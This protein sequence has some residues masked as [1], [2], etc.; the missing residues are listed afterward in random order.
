[1]S[2]NAIKRAIKSAGRDKFVADIS[3]DP[4]AFEVQLKSP[5]INTDFQETIWVYG[6]H[7]LDYGSS[8]QDMLEDL[9]MWMSDIEKEAA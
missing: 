8:V 2:L 7:N 3:E 6:K 1:M 9:D 4:W 5:W